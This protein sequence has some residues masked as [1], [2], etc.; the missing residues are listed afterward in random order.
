MTEYSTIHS[1]TKRN[2]FSILFNHSGTKGCS[3]GP[4]FC[5]IHKTID[6]FLQL[7]TADMEVLFKDCVDLLHHTSAI[8]QPTVEQFLKDLEG[9]QHVA[10]ETLTAII[11][12]IKVSTGRGRGNAH[13]HH[14]RYTG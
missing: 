2:I 12:D 9:L 7:Y 3:S 4:V 5:Q 11:T 14:R 8:Y 1:H 10:E 6:T 13:G